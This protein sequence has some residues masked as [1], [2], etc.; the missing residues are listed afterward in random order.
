MNRAYTNL[1]VLLFR[2]TNGTA[3]IRACAEG[4]GIKEI[5]AKKAFARLMKGKHFDCCE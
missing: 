1:Y 5:E 3:S 2:L 4:L